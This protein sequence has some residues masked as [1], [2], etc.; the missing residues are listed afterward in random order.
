MDGSELSAEVRR[1]GARLAGLAAQRDRLAAEGRRLRESVHPQEQQEAVRQR[2]RA[3]LELQHAETQLEAI[4][5]L[6]QL[7][8]AGKLDVEQAR[9]TQRLAALDLQQAEGALPLLQAQHGARLEEIASDLRRLDGDMEAERIAREEAARALA[10]GT[11]E[12]PV[13]GRIVTGSLDQLPGSAVKRGD[14]LVRI[15]RGAV[16]RFEGTVADAGQAAVRTGQRA[17]IR[18]EAYPWLLYRTLPGRVSRVAGRRLDPG[19]FPVEIVPELD[20]APGPLS[21]G[22]RGT[23]RIVVEEKVS[24]WRLLVEEVTGRRGP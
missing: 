2:D 17:K 13:A 10:Q 8:L 3:R 4:G 9:L 20:R 19:G 5:K 12:S 11:V 24:L 16:D 23:A 22:M 6:G 14:E 21:E 15:A 7:G 18:L 1:C